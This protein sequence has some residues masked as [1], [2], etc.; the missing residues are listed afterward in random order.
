MFNFVREEGICIESSGIYWEKS[1]VFE[2]WTK[3]YWSK[4]TKGME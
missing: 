4:I 3:D 2:V 1:F